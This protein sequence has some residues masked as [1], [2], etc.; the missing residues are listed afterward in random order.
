MCDQ[1]IWLHVFDEEVCH[2]PWHMVLR[3][4]CKHVP[5]GKLILHHGSFRHASLHDGMFPCYRVTTFLFLCDAQGRA[6]L[7][8]CNSSLNQLFGKHR[9]VSSLE[10]GGVRGRRQLC[11]VLKNGCGSSSTRIC[12]HQCC[13]RIGTGFFSAQ[14]ICS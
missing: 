14:N 12:G 10:E 1:F 13:S 2:S 11:K 4:L 7:A 8:T 5:A 9:P 6:Q 3:N